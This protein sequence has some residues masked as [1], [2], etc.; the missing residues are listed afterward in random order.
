VAVDGQGNVYVADTYNHRVQKLSPTG[1]P[2]AIWGG[3]GQLSFP[4][5]VALDQA[6][7]LFVSDAEGLKELALASGELVRQ[8]SEFGDPYGVALDGDGNVYV[9]DTDHARVVQLTPEGEP[10]ARWGGEGSGP[11]QFKLP[12]AIAVDGS[13]NVYVADR[14]NNRIQVLVR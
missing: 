8:W 3:V 7:N 12:E 4:H 9:A 6:G 1:Q 5:A 13:G 11:G 10:V 14:G 2:L